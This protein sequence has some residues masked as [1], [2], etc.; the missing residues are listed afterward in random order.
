[1]L[2]ENLFKLIVKLSGKLAYFKKIILLHTLY[3]QLG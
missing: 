1:M 3:M 2:H